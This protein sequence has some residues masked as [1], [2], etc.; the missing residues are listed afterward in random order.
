VGDANCAT[1][2]A[3]RAVPELVIM[4]GGSAAAAAAAAHVLWNLA[5]NDAGRRAVVEAKGLRPLVAMAAEDKGTPEG[6]LAAAGVLA[7]LAGEHKPS[8]LSSFGG[9]KVSI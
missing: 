7:N 2:L 3:G 9:F 1:L 4:L 5:A 6:R 8:V